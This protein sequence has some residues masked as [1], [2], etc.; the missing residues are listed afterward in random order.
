MLSAPL[1]Q[2]AI[3]LKPDD[4]G[5]V[6]LTL[7]LQDKQL[8]I[9][10]GVSSTEI[11]ERLHQDRALLDDM[12]RPVIGD[13]V[14]TVVTIRVADTDNAT[15]SF[16]NIGGGAAANPEQSS[17]G[18]ERPSTGKDDRSQQADGRT[19]VHE[20]PSPV[21]RTRPDILVL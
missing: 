5:T 2:F 20:E 16:G 6:S 17:T 11:A 4:L 8:S 15:G 9:A 14:M 19:A 21:L 13:M 18:R 10:I 12:L 1:R 7:R 3:K